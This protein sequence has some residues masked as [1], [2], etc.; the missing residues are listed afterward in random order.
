MAK[1]SKRILDKEL[2]Q[3][4][5]ELFVK[6]VIDLK[7]EQE[8]RNFLQDLLSPTEKIMLVKRLAIAILLTKGYTYDAIDNTLKVSRPT[9]MGVSYF[10]K[11]GN[12][13]YQ[14]AVDKIIRGQ[15]KEEFADK[16]EE[17]LLRMSLPKKEG[18]IGFEKKQKRGKELFRRR[19]RRGKI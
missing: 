19:I 3:R 14:K 16:I 12:S 15:K 1:V 17:L 11:Y 5:F 8:V 10:L 13:G 2:E 4:V 6:T 9:I 7:N 18:S